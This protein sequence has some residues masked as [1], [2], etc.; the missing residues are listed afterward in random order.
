MRHSKPDLDL[1]L[2]HVDDRLDQRMRDAIGADSAAVLPLLD[3]YSFTFLVEDP[4]TVWHLG[5]ERYDDLAARYNALT[6]HRNRLAIDINIVER[7]Q[8]VYPTRQ[9]TGMELLQLVGRASRVFPRVALYFENSILAADVPWLASAAAVVNRFESEGDQL[10]VESPNGVGIAWRG[11]AL[12]DGSLWPAAD[13]E[14]LWVPAG[15]HRVGPAPRFPA[16]RLLDLTGELMAAD[17]LAG[18]LEFSYR[19]DARAFAVV[20]KRP[21]RVEID[22]AVAHPQ[23]LDSISGITLCLPRGQ[24]LVRIHTE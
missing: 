22:G 20:D 4:A 6:A 8:D 2:T 16:V 19:S 10:L 5:P 21:Q 17:S 7:Y 23:M 15:R 1:V 3:R 13:G 14:T 24:H 12:V 18:G 9:Q 11:A